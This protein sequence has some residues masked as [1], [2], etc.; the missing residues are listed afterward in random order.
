M[1]PEGSIW[2]ARDVVST[3]RV[4]DEVTVIPGEAMC[5]LWTGWGESGSIDVHGTFQDSHSTDSACPA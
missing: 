3:D 1:N 2:S 5:V 4:C